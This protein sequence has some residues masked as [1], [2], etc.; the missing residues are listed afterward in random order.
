MAK[1]KKELKKYLNYEFFIWWLYWRRLQKFERLYINYLKSL[2]KDNGW[3]L[4]KVNKNHYGVF[5]FSF[6]YAIIDTFT[7]VLRCVRFLE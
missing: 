4:V 2:L 7:S 5:I 3:E 1:I 6:F